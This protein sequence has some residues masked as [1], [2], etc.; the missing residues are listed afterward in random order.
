VSAG[1]WHREE[2][3]NVLKMSLL[4]WLVGCRQIENGEHG[5]VLSWIVLFVVIFFFIVWRQY[6]TVA[7]PQNIIAQP[8]QVCT[9]PR[10]FVR[11]VRQ[12]KPV[13]LCQQRLCFRF[14]RENVDQTVRSAD[15]EQRITVWFWSP[16][17][18][19]DLARRIDDIRFWWVGRICLQNRHC[20]FGC[21]HHQQLVRT[22][23][24]LKRANRS[25][26]TSSKVSG[27]SS[28]RFVGICSKMT[29]R[30]W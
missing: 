27:R 21:I 13:L 14:V 12:V 11:V 17:S 8:L 16:R 9:N 25:C 1:H 15:G 26:R 2:C 24:K 10:I 28:C 18:T 4:F 7:Y 23:P 3:D 20:L 5:L 30:V 19:S 6:T 22:R 29:V